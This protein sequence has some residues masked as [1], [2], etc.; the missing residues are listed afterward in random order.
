[1]EARQAVAQRYSYGLSGVVK[2]PF[3][4]AGS[5]SA[6][7]QYAIET[8]HR[9]APKAYLQENEIPS[10]IYYVKPLHLQQAY[11]G[12]PR[13]GGIPVSESLSGRILC[14]PM[15]PYLSDSDQDRVIDAIR[16]F[17]VSQESAAAAE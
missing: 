6:W 15:H 4:P 16:D 5:R 11:K 12:F 8:P 7:A 10:V 14:L 9:D 2:T 13:A 17:V 1:M 3:L